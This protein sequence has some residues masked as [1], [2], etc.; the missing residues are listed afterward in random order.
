MLQIFLFL[1][2]IGA[3]LGFGVCIGDALATRRWFNETIARRL[4]EY[5]PR[6]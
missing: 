4:N 3:V 2:V 1:L 6:R 5:I